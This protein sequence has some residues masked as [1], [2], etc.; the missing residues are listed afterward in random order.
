MSTNFAKTLVWKQYYDVKSWRH[1]Q[2]TT[3]TNDYPMSLNENPPWKFSAYATVVW[4]CLNRSAASQVRN[5][6]TGI[7]AEVILQFIDQQFS[8]NMQPSLYVTIL[9]CFASL[10]EYPYLWEV[11][12]LK[13][14]E[15]SASRN[16]ERE[17]PIKNWNED[18]NICCLH[19][20]SV[21]SF[22]AV[23]NHGFVCTTSYFL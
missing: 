10:S 7:G 9:R 14:H 13:K 23:K 15:F 22:Y 5:G 21:S 1:K 17:I 8:C 4:T 2:R 3:N 12:P 6:V 16:R 18:L 19:L 11:S 20:K